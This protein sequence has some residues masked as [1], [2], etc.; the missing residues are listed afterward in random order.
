MLR[1]LASSDWLVWSVVSKRG[2][3]VSSK[4]L[5]LFSEAGIYSPS[6]LSFPRSWFEF[7]KLWAA[8]AAVASPQDVGPGRQH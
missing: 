8:A 2:H 3:K 1:G 7:E 6:S 4:V 5:D